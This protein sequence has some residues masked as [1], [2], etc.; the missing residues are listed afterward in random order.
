M[1]PA[2][3]TKALLRAA[4]QL[5]LSAD[6]ATLMRMSPGDLVHLQSGASTLDPQSDEWNRALQIIGLF[7]TLVL[8]VGSAEHARHWLVQPN[9][10]LAARPI[11]LLRSQEEARVY[12]YLDAVQKHELRL[13]GRRDA[14]SE[15]DS[16]DT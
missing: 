12:R 6:L 11:D 3:L 9:Q 5:D 8:L 10:A 14:G 16:R 15:P 2:T 4:E 1:T 13:P 7:R